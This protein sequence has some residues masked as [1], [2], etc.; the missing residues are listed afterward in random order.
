[1]KQNL[2]F[3]YIYSKET[4]WVCMYDEDED[5]DADL[6]VQLCYSMVRTKCRNQSVLTEM[7]PKIEYSF[8]RKNIII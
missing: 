2:V 5:S 8:I 4:C 6:E 7:S 3:W 1:M